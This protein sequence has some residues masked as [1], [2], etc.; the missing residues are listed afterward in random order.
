MDQIAQAWGGILRQSLVAFRPLVEAN[1]SLDFLRQVP[2]GDRFGGCFRMGEAEQRLLAV[3]EIGPFQM[4]AFEQRRI[5]K[6]MHVDKN[7]L[8][9]VMKKAGDKCV[10]DEMRRDAF[11]KK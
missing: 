11:T 9:D 8:A 3:L 4:N 7:Q 2:V 5:L 1:R 6:R 10:F